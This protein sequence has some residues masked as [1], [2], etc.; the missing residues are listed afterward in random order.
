MALASADLV[1]GGD[2]VVVVVSD[3]WPERSSVSL[4]ELRRIYLG[5]LTRT[6]SLRVSRLD[7]PPGSPDPIP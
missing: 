7:Q 4:R 5:T 3:A 2:A 1:R 6:D